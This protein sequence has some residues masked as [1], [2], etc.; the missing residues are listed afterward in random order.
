MVLRK[1]DE[2]KDFCDVTLAS[3]GNQQNETHKVIP[4]GSS[5]FFRDMLKVLL[6]YKDCGKMSHYLQ[7]KFPFS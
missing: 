6:I 7:G 3:K 2:D 5:P 4:A 1:Q